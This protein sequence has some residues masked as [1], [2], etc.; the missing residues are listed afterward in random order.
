MK[1]KIQELTVHLRLMEQ[2]GDIKLKD[3]RRDDFF[4]ELNQIDIEAGKI[5]PDVIEFEDDDET[6]DREPDY[7]QCMSCGN[8]QVNS[9]GLTCNKCAGPTTEQY[10]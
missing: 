1:S 9:T 2:R 4:T 5:S 6:E 7:Y 8:V 3:V 10:L